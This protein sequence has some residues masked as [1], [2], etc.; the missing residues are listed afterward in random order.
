MS[1]YTQEQLDI[2]AEL[3]VLSNQ[4]LNMGMPQG[5]KRRTAIAEARRTAAIHL[6]RI[7]YSH[8]QIAEV[9]NL[10]SPQSV[11]VYIEEKS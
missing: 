10:K 7:G 5:A 4:I 2:A 3:G 8:R 6:H 1:K 9:L 11:S